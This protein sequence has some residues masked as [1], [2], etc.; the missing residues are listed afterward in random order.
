MIA[1]LTPQ[2]V[3]TSLLLIILTAPTLTL[4]LSAVLLWRYR[5]AVTRAMHATAAFHPSLRAR[6]SHHR[7]AASGHS[8][9]ADTYRLA[10]RGPWENAL[11]H[12][13]AG[14]AFALV[15]AVAARFVY[16]FRLDWA[17]F[18]IGI[19]VYLWP[20]VLAVPLIVQGRPR[21]WAVSTV[22]YFVVF[23]VLGLVAASIT[24]M[25]EF[26]FGGIDLSAR[27]AV[28]PRGM[29][30]LWLTVN[31]VPTF[32]VLVCFHR[33]VRAVAPLVLALVTTVIAG[34][35]LALL[36]IFSSRGAGATDTLAGATAVPEGWLV[37]AAVVLA[38]V[39]FAVAGWALARWIGRAYQRRRLSDQ[40]LL[41]DALWLLFA[42]FYTMWLALGGL[43]WTATAPVAFLVYTLVLV[44]W[45]RASPVTSSAAVGLTF[46]RVFALGRRS[47]ALFE[48]LASSWRHVGRVQLIT[49]PDV[50][51]TTV[52]PHQ[53][54]D[55]L[56]GK[57]T[58]H[59]VR[60]AETL[61][62]RLAERERDRDPDGRFRISNFFCHADTWEAALLRLVEEGDAV[63]MDLRSFSAANRGC[64]RELQHLVGHVPLERWLL[65]VDA[66]TDMPFLERTL[67]EAWA[68]AGAGSPN[69]GRSMR[70]AAVV[71]FETGPAA[72]R[73]LLRQLSG[74]DAA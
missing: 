72:L 51:L 64:T 32:L 13:V 59:F 67:E 30:T 66:T 6:G 52:Q 26:R 22:V 19:W 73:G 36:T 7:D 39:G 25:P 69:A 54:L 4:L 45:R 44:A 10:R 60:D 41:L 57:L 43:R 55:Y 31:G 38:V 23:A 48:A 42:S 34:T 65:V 3:T 61:E 20:V 24:D 58:R 74:A 1:E 2:I 71:R 50:A 12:G 15:F 14:L 16:P 37:L 11:R 27:S 62:A 18:L 9:G 53:F 46:L 8:A 28:T 33:R 63:L 68:Q 29:A 40:S 49:G 35:W 21:L 5:R 56:S 17:G 47:E 70:E